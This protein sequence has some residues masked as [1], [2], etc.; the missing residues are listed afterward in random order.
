[1]KKKNVIS[2]LLV[3]VMCIG[4][5]GLTGCGSSADKD[6]S[7]D[8]TDKSEKQTLRITY[9]PAPGVAEDSYAQ[10]LNQAYQG[11]DKKDE[12]ELELN[13]FEGA[14]SD[15]LTKI[16]LMMQDESQCGDIVYEDTFQLSSD[17]AAGYLANLSPYLDEYKEWNDGTF[18]EATKAATICDDGNYYGIPACTDSR[19]LL[20][21]KNV[22][23]AAGLGVDWQPK[24]WDELLEG[25]RQIKEKCA[26]VIPFW[27]IVGKANGEAASMNGY[28]ML[29]YG[30]KD[31]GQSLYNTDEQKWVAS[32]E[33]IE[34]AN[35]FVVDIFEGGLTGEYSEM[36]DTGSDGYAMDYLRQD[37]LGIYLIGSWFPQNFQTGGAYEWAEYK[38]DLN[39]IPMPTED[40]SGTVTMS[41]GWCWSVPE[42]S[43]NKDLA[44]D[45]L[46]EMYKAENYYTFISA[47]SNLPTIDMSDFPELA[48]KPFYDVA[49]SMLDSALFRPKNEQYSSVS[50]YIAQMSE[51]AATGLDAKAAMETYASNV[52]S[53][54]GADNIIKE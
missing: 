17:M 13:K 20:V 8:K 10:M 49:E 15:Y 11:W 37:K 32:S 40:G 44:F 16:Q 28:E 41:G 6:D 24:D 33:S 9:R 35:Q 34:T 54:V 14:D 27:M 23:E 2:F 21:N 46:Q 53:V 7:A 31:G 29:L 42:R 1:M 50:T 26:D 5:V 39:F 47:E 18:I 38:D 30:T 51:D 43:A 36:L 25:C 3:V 19:G 48:E 45:F 4:T 22:L 52:E 12:V